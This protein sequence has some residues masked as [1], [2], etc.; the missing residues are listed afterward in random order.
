MKTI[1][2]YIK[3]MIGESISEINSLWKT[4]ESI[5]INY[6]KVSSERFEEIIQRVTP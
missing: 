6:S 3:E 2:K 5:K 4:G 1:E